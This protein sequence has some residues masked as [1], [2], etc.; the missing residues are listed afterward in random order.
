MKNY[1]DSDYAVNKHAS[2]IVYR[3]ANQTVEVTLEDYLQE[4]PS[5]TKADFTKLK[6][7]SDSDYFTRDRKGYR[8][9]WK[10]IPLDY[11][12]DSDIYVTPSPEDALTSKPELTYRQ[13]RKCKNA[14]KAWN[15]LSYIQQRRYFMSR[16]TGLSTHEIAEREGSNQK[17]VY[18]SIHAA[19][20]KIKQYMTN[21]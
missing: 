3:F 11:L 13:K 17:S 21:G 7:L 4:N 20:K 14:I 5:K 19:E 10:N 16:V 18:E 6:K 1:Q 12:E 9:S 15:K 2:G 8:Q